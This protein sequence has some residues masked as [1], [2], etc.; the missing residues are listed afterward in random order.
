MTCCTID[1]FSAWPEEALQ[2][3][4]TSFLHELPQLD[5]S[6]EAMRGMVGVRRVCDFHHVFVF[7]QHSLQLTDL[8]LQTIMCM[9]IHQ[10]VARKCDQYLAEL[11]RYNYVTP[12]SYLELLKIFSDLIRLKKQE[13]C[14]ARQRMKTGL[15]KARC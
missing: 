1:W 9:K 4:A 6:P 2:A 3:V 7:T 12:K 14:S 13:L 15:D 10:T 5:A 11:S 8:L